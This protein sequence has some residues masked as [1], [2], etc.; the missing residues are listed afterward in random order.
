MLLFTCDV[1]ENLLKFAREYRNVM[2]QIVISQT[3]VL[4]C[5]LFQAYN[6]HSLNCIAIESGFVDE[7]NCRNV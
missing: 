5:I 2:L 3:V 7:G 4:C 6:L 1:T